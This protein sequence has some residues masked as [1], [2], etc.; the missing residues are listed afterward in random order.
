MPRHVSHYCKLK[1]QQAISLIINLAV[2]MSK[3]LTAWAQGRVCRQLRM[4]R[5]HLELA[6]RQLRN[7]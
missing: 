7:I 2:K 3:I 4:F 1:I 5:V 6:H